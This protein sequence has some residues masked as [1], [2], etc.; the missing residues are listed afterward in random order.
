MLLSNC[1][2]HRIWKLH[3]RAYGLDDA[4]AALRM[5]PQRFPVGAANSSARA[6]LKFQVSSLGPCLYFIFR[7]SGGGPGAIATHIYNILE[8]GEPDVL[9]RACHFPGHR[10]G[11]LKVQEKSFVLEGVEASQ[12]NDFSAQLAQAEFTKGLKPIRA[13][14]DLWAA[15]RRPLSLGEIKVCQCRLGGLC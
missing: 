8:C 1:M 14:P 4:S 6:V 7:K 9:P 11:A 10:F 2:H 13:S 15:R 12:A 3:A 5:A